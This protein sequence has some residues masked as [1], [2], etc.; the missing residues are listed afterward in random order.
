MPAT[1]EWEADPE[2]GGCVQVLRSHQLDTHHQY[3]VIA[4][5]PAYHNQAI[6]VRYIHNHMPFSPHQAPVTVWLQLLDEAD[7]TASP[8][9]AFEYVPSAAPGMQAAKF[10]RTSSGNPD[11]SAYQPH[12]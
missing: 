1:S 12:P 6:M 2:F 8:P 7:E 4:E 10:L 3:V 11:W 5:M 9:A